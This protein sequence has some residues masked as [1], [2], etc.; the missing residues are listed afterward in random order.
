MSCERRILWNRRR[1]SSFDFHGDKP[2]ALPGFT[3][4]ELLVVIAVIGVM[5]GLLLPAVLQSIENG[6]RM[7]CQSNLQ[8]IALA[9]NDFHSTFKRYPVSVRPIYPDH[10]SVKDRR[11]SA[12]TQIL[13]FLQQ[14][15]IHSAYQLNKDW[16]DNTTPAGGRNAQDATL[17]QSAPTNY[18]LSTIEI[19]TYQCPS[20]PNSRRRDHDPQV[21]TGYD[22]AT[23]DYSPVLGVSYRLVD[24]NYVSTSPKPNY[25]P[26]D[27]SG[28][29]ILQQII[30]VPSNIASPFKQTKQSRISDVRDG[31]SNTIMFAES[32]GR[33]SVYRRNRNMS[34]SILQVRIN[35]GGWAR[36]ASDF[37]IDGSRIL[38]T[39]TW[40]AEFPGTPG[41]TQPLT[42]INATNGEDIGQST[43]DSTSG[44]FGYGIQNNS[45]LNRGRSTAALSDAAQKGPLGTGEIFSFHAGGSMCVFGDRSV[46]FLSESTD[47]RELARLV[48]RDASEISP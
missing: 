33:P 5:M 45:S 20:T 21:G 39:N 2:K 42:C 4:V 18:A 41:S 26:V 46:R 37:F 38:N 1:N 15:N 6:R 7:K 28:P 40:A 34:G 22:F 24:S 48:T 31:L 12:L 3:L 47:I 10:P 9:A 14:S 29:G 25:P 36:P 27:A 32:S 13:P 35:G 11:I 19:G 30:P 17:I 43:F 16:S 44:P 23:T 8:E